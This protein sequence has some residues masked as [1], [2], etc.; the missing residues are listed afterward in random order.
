M[1]LPSV[2][3]NPTQLCWE[4]E[5]EDKGFCSAIYKKKEDE[6][7]EVDDDHVLLFTQNRAK[8][9]RKFQVICNCLCVIVLKKNL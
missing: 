2:Q 7:V 5:N 4:T 8:T 1:M 6:N 3:K 9:I